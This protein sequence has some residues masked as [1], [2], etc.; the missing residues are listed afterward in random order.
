MQKNECRGEDH[1]TD[2]NFSSGNSGNPTHC[3]QNQKIGWKRKPKRE[4]FYILNKLNLPHHDS[5]VAFNSLANQQQQKQQKQQKLI[6]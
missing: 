1:C 4:N 3:D 6:F 5:F 2:H